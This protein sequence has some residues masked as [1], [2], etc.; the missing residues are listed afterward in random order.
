MW[1]ADPS[2]RSSERS[3]AR[4]ARGLAALALIA[5]LTAAAAW[6]YAHEGHQA[7]PT[8]GVEIVRDHEGEATGV[9]LGPE[10]LRALDVRTADVVPV[11]LDDHLAAPAVVVAPWDRHAF[12]AA[13][14]G[15]KA[16]ALFVRPGDA[17][18][19]GQVVA[20]VESLE[21]ADLQREL[22]D[23]RAE[24]DLAARN[25]ADLEEGSRRGS[26]PEKEL[27]E[28]EAQRRQSLDSLDVSRRK[29]LGLGAPAE[30]V[31]G[32]LRGDRRPLR[33]LPVRSPVAGAAIHV[34]VGV[35]QVV[36]PGEHLVE[37]VDLSR[38]WVKVAVLEK[39]L[40]RV[41]SGLD[42]EL[43]FPA[44]GVSFL[45]GKV[46]GAVRVLDPAGRGAAWVD[47]DNP[48]GRLL[49]GMIGHA[50]IRLPAARTGLLIPGS[51]L[52]TEGAESFVLAETA[53][54]QYRRQN[55]IVEARQGDRVQVSRATGL[56]PGDRVVTEGGHELAGLFVRGTLRLSPEAERSIGLKVEPAARRPIAETV[57]LTGVVDLPPG[58]RA[59]ASSRLAGVVRRLAVGRDEEVAAGA[60]LAEVFTPELLSLQLDLLHADSQ[61]RLLDGT[62]RGL[63]SA[64]KDA[65]SGRAVREAESALAAARLKSDSLRR[66]L[67]EAGLRPEDLRALREERKVVE[68][69]PVRAPVGGAVVRFQAALGQAVK[70]EAPLFEIHDLSGALLRVHVP[71]RLLSAVRVGQE[72]RVRLEGAPGFVGRAALVRSAPSLDGAGRTVAFWADLRDRP[73]T[74]LPGMFARLSLEV[75]GPVPALAAPVDAVLRDGAGAWVFVR[76]KDGSF[77]RREVRTG[78]SDDRFTEITEGLSEGET[79]AVRGV[80]DLQTAFA[81]LQ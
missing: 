72:G 53:P 35:G 80:A 19:R 1:R 55:V 60:V 75:G 52:L 38:V 17:V 77:E 64:P 13:P 41:V 25:L 2:R 33:T 27:R 78:S 63:R 14:L 3:R 59:V 23:A 51:A 4:R 16:A 39:D 20:E 28:A 62:L 18:A 73:P 32:L 40:H 43:R 24:A 68:A 74:L 54:G 47:L 45:S 76:R 34:D 58:R 6:L 22:L 11:S 79:I 44:A 49:P 21:L 65:A 36:E 9:N 42:V 15:G 50:R 37:V 10:S 46:G 8:R 29:L 81:A 57:A 12:A 66:K 48:D 61:T 7:L 67:L 69:L 31:E 5:L 30:S 26:V 71:E 70:A 56:F